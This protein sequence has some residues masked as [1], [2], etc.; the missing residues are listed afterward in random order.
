MK[1]MLDSELIA[2]LNK[3]ADVNT[4][5]MSLPETVV[6][7]KDLSTVSDENC[8]WALLNNNSYIAILRNG[9]G[10]PFTCPKEGIESFL[11]T[12]KEDKAENI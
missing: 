9:D 7:I 10:V 12:L 6:K 11:S 2:F 1:M 3:L 8:K 4:D 5:N